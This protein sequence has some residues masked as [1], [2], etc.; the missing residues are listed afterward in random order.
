MELPKQDYV[1]ELALPGAIYADP[2]VSEALPQPQQFGA[3]RAYWRI[4]FDLD[5]A[6]TQRPAGITLIAQL[7]AA[8]REDA[9]DLV[10]DIGLRVLQAIAFY[11]GSPKS[12]PR[13]VRLSRIGASGRILEQNV[14]FYLEEP[15][16]LARIELPGVAVLDA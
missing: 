15:E 8:H 9:E 6:G 5:S 12:R 14:Y 11:S 10:L 3:L 7:K 2:K 16:S 13:L 4:R 1:G